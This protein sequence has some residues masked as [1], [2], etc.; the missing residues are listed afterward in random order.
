MS[1]KK[2]K[3]EA[4]RVEAGRKGGKSRSRKKLQAAR[5]NAEV[6]GRPAT[7]RYL[8]LR[9]IE[10]EMADNRVAWLRAKD[11]GAKALLDDRFNSLVRRKERLDGEACNG[12]V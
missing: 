10:K 7:K 6:Y 12:N 8:K 1:N 5:I 2:H 3:K 9:A 4:W 11:N